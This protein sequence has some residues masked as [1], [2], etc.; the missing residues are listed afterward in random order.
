MPRCETDDDCMILALAS[1]PCDFCNFLDCLPGGVM[2][3]GFWVNSVLYYMSM[4][5]GKG[6]ERKGKE[7]ESVWYE[8]CWGYDRGE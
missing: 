7:R 4:K 3:F 8:R 2:G 5:G 6:T 1:F